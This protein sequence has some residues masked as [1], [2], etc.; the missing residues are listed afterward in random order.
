MDAEPHE[1]H[2]EQPHEAHREATKLIFGVQ[3]EFV[4]EDYTAYDELPLMHKLEIFVVVCRVAA[5]SLR[6]H[7]TSACWLSCR[8]W[9]TCSAFTQEH[10]RIVCELHGDVSEHLLSDTNLEA[11][12]I[13]C[14]LTE[15]FHVQKQSNDEVCEPWMNEQL[16]FL[17]VFK[18]G[19]TSIQ[20]VLS[21]LVEVS[22]LSDPAHPRY[23]KYFWFDL[24]ADARNRSRS[25][26][27]HYVR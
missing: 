4:K 18:S 25:L 26:R 19:G 21:E 6:V 11:Y 22:T 12:A 3:H 9:A 10:R 2:T 1:P 20:S 8:W 7:C 17:H 16:G 24:W 15:R 13:R 14:R 27:K 23:S 5:Q